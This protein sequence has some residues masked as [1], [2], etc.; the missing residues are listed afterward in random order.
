MFLRSDDEQ[1][2]SLPLLWALHGY[3]KPSEKIIRKNS[4]G[5]K[6]TIKF[7][8]KDSQEAFIYIGKSVQELENHIEFLKSRSENIQPFILGI[9]EDIPIYHK[10]VYLYLDG[11]K[12]QFI[13]FLRAVDMFS[14][15]LFL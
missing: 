11:V 2:G 13:N 9:G 7:T 15:F 5:K 10:T 14:S 6:E 1:N 3:L 12:L 4:T 8:I